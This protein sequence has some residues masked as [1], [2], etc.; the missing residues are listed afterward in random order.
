M[1]PRQLIAEKI[2][3]GNFTQSMDADNLSAI[4]KALNAIP[5]TGNGVI[6]N[7]AF[8]AWLTYNQLYEFIYDQA[9]TQG[10]PLRNYCLRI[11]DLLA[12]PGSPINLDNPANIGILNTLLSAKLGGDQAAID[13]EKASLFLYA[14]RSSWAVANLDR[15]TSPTE[16]GA[17]M[18]FLLSNI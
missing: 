10:S 4:A 7:A 14:K 6:S 15:I 11:R 17:A 12:P 16:V 9:D 13:A 3:A 8:G 2:K 1:D 18:S 5:D